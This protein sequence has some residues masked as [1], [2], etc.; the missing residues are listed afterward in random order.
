MGLTPDWLIVG[1]PGQKKGGC[2]W[3]A[4]KAGAGAFGRAVLASLGSPCQPTTSHIAA[5]AAPSLITAVPSA[6][7]A[8]PPNTTRAPACCVAS[9]AHPATVGASQ[10]ASAHPVVAGG[11]RLSRVRAGAAARAPAL[12]PAPA[13]PLHQLQGQAA[14]R[15]A[16]WGEQQWTV[17][18]LQGRAGL[19][20]VCTLRG[21]G[22]ACAEPHLL[23]SKRCSW[24]PTSPPRSCTTSG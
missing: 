22:A 17:F 13:G 20:C 19:A 9:A 5:A 10:P 8:S 1:W 3:R 14:A 21:Q 24:P 18:L 15:W 6:G 11:G 2:A 23:L 4:A 7:D 16:W 12:H